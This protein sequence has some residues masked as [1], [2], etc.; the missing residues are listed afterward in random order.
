MGNLQPRAI[1]NI[2]ESLQ[3]RRWLWAGV[4]LAGLISVAGIA[5]WAG[6][7]RDSF[8]EPSCTPPAPNAQQAG[9]VATVPIRDVNIG[10]TSTIGL[11]RDG[12][13]LLLAGALPHDK[14]T[15]VLQALDVAERREVWRVPVEGLGFYPKLAISGNDDKLAIWGTEPRIRIVDMQNGKTAAELATEK[16]YTRHYFDVSFSDDN[17]G[18]VTG[19][20][21]RRRLL[22]L[23]D[24][25]AEPAIA[26]GFESAEERCSGF[27]GQSNTGHVRSRDGK[28]SVILLKAFGSPIWIGSYRPSSELLDAVCGAGHVV[29][30]DSPRD[31]KGAEADFTSFSPDGRRLAVVYL[32]EALGRPTRS[33]IV[34]WDMTAMHPRHFLT[35]PMDGIVGFRIAWAADS[36]QLAAIRSNTE[37]AEARIYAIPQDANDTVPAL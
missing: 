19:D 2:A 11:S 17:A 20:A 36:R 4:A 34:V 29:I 6:W 33:F 22:R 10:L 16:P 30:L 5:V 13:R 31:L 14:T 24:P 28:F 1:Q 21:T 18:I 35:F 7:P 23:S 25:T 27:V 9:C 26:P 12:T 8:V 3:S 32:D 15:L 37:G